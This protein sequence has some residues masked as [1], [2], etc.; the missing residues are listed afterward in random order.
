MAPYGWSAQHSVEEWLYLHPE[1]F[2]FYQAVRLFEWQ[3]ADKLVPLG[4]TAAP[5]SE[6]IRFPFGSL[7]RFCP[8]GDCGHRFGH[9]AV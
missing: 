9:A 4:E 7:F 2:D 5:A 3:R 8:D 1:Q 6:S